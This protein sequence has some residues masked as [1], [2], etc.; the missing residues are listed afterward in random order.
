MAD[1]LPR[2]KRQGIERRNHRRIPIKVLVKYERMDD[3]LE[4]YTANVS[5]GGMFIQTDDPLPL[6][7][8]FRLRFQ[9]PNLT[10]TIEAEATVQWVH[11]PDEAGP[12][13]A[14]MGVRFDELAATDRAEVEALLENWDEG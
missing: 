8:R 5:L 7:T 10:R 12:L 6:G 14:G 9:L 11:R 2:S 4:D 13:T 1:E 3:F